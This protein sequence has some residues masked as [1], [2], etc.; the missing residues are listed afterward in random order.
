MTPRRWLVAG[1]VLS[2][3]ATVYTAFAPLYSS[4]SSSS[5]GASSVGTASLIEVN[6]WGGLIPG[7][8]LVALAFGVWQAKVSPVRWVLLGMFVILVVV[9]LLTLGIYYVPAAVCLVIGALRTKD[10]VTP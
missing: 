3:L 8:L 7:L 2:V 1:F 10:P 9:G 4:S 6:G 5:D